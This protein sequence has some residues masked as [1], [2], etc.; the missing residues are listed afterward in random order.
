[1]WHCLRIALPFFPAVV[2]CL[3]GCKEQPKDPKRVEFQRSPFGTLPIE[4]ASAGSMKPGNP[5]RRRLLA[6][7]RDGSDQAD[8]QRQLDVSLIK[9]PEYRAAAG[10]SAGSAPG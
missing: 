8:R 3:R 1:M 7:E 10:R 5:D 6:L 2:F 4:V 9:R